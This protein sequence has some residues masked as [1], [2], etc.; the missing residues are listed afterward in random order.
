MSALDAT[1][2]SWDRLI[3]SVQ[4]V[5]LML[6]NRS[7]KEKLAEALEAVR[8]KQEAEQ[9]TDKVVRELQV[10]RRTP[11]RLSRTFEVPRFAWCTE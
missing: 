5:C 10:R 8:Q 9:Q 1:G 4:C 3:D 7:L 11:F 2:D 6:E